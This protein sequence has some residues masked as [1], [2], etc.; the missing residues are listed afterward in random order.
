MSTR[1]LVRAAFCLGGALLVDCSGPDQTI[2]PSFATA[3]RPQVVVTPSQA[4]LPVGATQQFQAMLVDPTGQP[5]AERRFTW[6][7]SNT[8]VAT[9]SA[10]G[11][12]TAVATGSATITATTYPFSGTA[13]V[14]VVASPTATHPAGVIAATTPLADRPF[15]AAVSR[16]GTFLV[17]RGDDGVGRGDL[18]A[19]TFPAN[20]TVGAVPTQVAFSPSGGRAY[21]TNQLSDNLGVIDVATNT[22]VKTIP[23]QG[24]PF[25]VAA[26]PDGTTVYVTDNVGH[27][28]AI[29]AA[30]ETLRNTLTFPSLSNGLV[31]NPSGSRVYASLLFTSEIVEIDA[32]ADTVIRSIPIGGGALQG[33]A[34]ATDGSELYVADQSFGLLRVVSVA[35]G[36][37]IAQVPVS[38]DAF[39]VAVSPD[40]AQVYVGLPFTGVVRVID[41]A[42]RSVVSTIS[43]GG[44]PRRI[45]FSAGGETAVIANESGWVNFVQ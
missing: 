1:L 29:D 17:T 27:V 5:H 43:T 39:A 7:S 23:L 38:G 26:S 11:L 41:R 16:G 4:T 20:V 12:V 35:S 9:V 32:H 10:T 6:Q 22:Q 34:I 36:T 2:A 30:T 21:V 25:Y 24:D 14:T 18:P 42:S 40:N 28:Y 45:A 3:S 44:T 13:L 33:I 8:G 31:F 37:E 15:G 19:F